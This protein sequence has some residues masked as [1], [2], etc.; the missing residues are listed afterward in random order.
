MVFNGAG[1]TEANGL[2]RSCYFSISKKFRGSSDLSYREI[3]QVLNLPRKNYMI[4]LLVA[5]D[6]AG[7]GSFIASSQVRGLS[8]HLSHP[9]IS[10][11]KCFRFS[12]S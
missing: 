6:A 7:I 8:G 1:L 11:I 3:V 10:L 9:N 2:F 5:L 4:S 12:F